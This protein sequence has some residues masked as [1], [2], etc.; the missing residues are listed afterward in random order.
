MV[1]FD[2]LPGEVVLLVVAAPVIIA[3]EHMT[4]A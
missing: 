2:Y 1:M 3:F 4:I